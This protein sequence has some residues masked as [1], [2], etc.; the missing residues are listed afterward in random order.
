MLD[1]AGLDASARLVHCRAALEVVADAVRQA[2][3]DIPWHIRDHWPPDVAEAAA[4]LVERYVPTAKQ[5]RGVITTGL[6]DLDSKARQ[7]FLTF[8]PFAYEAIF[9]NGEGPVAEVNDEGQSVVVA[10]TSD[11]RDRLVQ[12]VDAA[13]VVPLEAWREAHLGH[14]R[15]MAERL[16]HRR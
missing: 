15:R 2:E 14:L 9:W 10:L 6:R 4:R 8:A 5:D 16:K 1:S 3:T 11:E 13:R 12:S 7:D